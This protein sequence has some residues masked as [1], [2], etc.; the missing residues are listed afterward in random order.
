VSARRVWRLVNNLSGMTKTK[1]SGRKNSEMTLGW[2][3]KFGKKNQSAGDRSL[4]VHISQ[5]A[6]LEK[7]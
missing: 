4:A 5:L 1:A 3:V 2:R 6:D 7:K